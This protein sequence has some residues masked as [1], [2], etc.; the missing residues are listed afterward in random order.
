VE[1]AV[2]TWIVIHRI[3]DGKIAETWAATLPG[4]AWKDVSQG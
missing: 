1:H 3:A 2:I 4:V